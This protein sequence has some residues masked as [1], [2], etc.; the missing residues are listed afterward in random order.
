MTVERQCHV[1]EGPGGR[2]LL[3]EV[4]GPPEGDVVLAHTGTPQSGTVYGPKVVAGA[5]RGLRHIAY[6]RPGYAG[7]ERQPGRCIA[8]CAADV[9]AIADQL[10]IG[11]FYTV[12]QSGGGPHA[13]ACA[14][15]LGD[16]VRAAAMGRP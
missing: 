14:A 4:A 6:S 2:R 11:R 5:E 16:R 7:S 13:L 8:D 1:V 9:A 15:L 3:V 10:G 12:G